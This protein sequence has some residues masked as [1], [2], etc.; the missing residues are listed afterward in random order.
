[1]TTTT[2]QEAIKGARIGAE[3]NGI[4]NAAHPGGTVTLKDRNLNG[5]AVFQGQTADLIFIPLSHDGSRIE[6]AS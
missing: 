6:R 2:V 4:G 3:F 5:H 1:M